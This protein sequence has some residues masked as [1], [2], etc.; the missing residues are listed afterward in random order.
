MN[1]NLLLSN[2][3]D[4]NVQFIN[5]LKYQVR[6]NPKKHALQTAKEVE[7]VFI[8][9]LLKSM[10]SSLLKDNLLDNNQSRLYTDIYDQQL[11]QEIS[12]KGIGLTDI[13][14][15]QIEK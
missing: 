15:K 3:S 14:L 10:R 13:I 4:Y 9:V 12:K 5:E 8:Q 7:G 11:S 1:D 6:I 2:I